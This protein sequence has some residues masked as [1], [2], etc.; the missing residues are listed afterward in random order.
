MGNSNSKQDS[1]Q[2]L[3]MHLSGWNEKEQKSMVKPDCSL[4]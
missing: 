1:T 4:V 3:I 2:K